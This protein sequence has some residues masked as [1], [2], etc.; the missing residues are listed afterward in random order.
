MA[1]ATP[2]NAS[3][4]IILDREDLFVRPYVF[5]YTD[6]RPSIVYLLARRRRFPKHLRQTRTLKTDAAVFKAAVRDHEAG[7][8]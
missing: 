2:E 5:A 4:E 7:R 3:S 6:A 1:A 8:L